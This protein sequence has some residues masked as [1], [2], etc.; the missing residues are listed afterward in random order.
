MKRRPNDGEIERPALRSAKALFGLWL[1]QALSFGRRA[2]I[3][4]SPENTN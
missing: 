4:I 1:A 3:A 2:M